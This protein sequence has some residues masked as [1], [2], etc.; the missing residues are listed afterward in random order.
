MAVSYAQFYRLKDM[1][2]VHALHQHAPALTKALLIMLCCAVQAATDCLTTVSWVS[3]FSA[4]SRSGA[5]GVIASFA[6]EALAD[7]EA[8]TG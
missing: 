4:A 1:L 3:R 6:W 5:D 2:V 7:P 8:G